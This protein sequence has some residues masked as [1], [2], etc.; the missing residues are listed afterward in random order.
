MLL[1]PLWPVA[2]LDDGAD[3]APPVKSEA[4]PGTEI[5][6]EV[7]SAPIFDDAAG[8]AVRDGKADNGL[9]TAKCG[10]DVLDGVALL[11]FIGGVVMDIG[12]GGTEGI[13]L[14]LRGGGPFALTA[15]DGGPLGGGGGAAAIASAGPPF[16]LTH[17]FRSSS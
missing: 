5:S 11:I 16:L 9:D 13:G 10:E 2:G 4:V 6:D 15:L 14:E 7:S 1:A 17:F 8:E 3:G 12:R